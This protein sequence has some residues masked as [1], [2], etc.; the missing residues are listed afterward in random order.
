MNL[1]F[2]CPKMRGNVENKNN[3]VSSGNL[4]NNATTQ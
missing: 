1:T 4:T 3:P 2:F